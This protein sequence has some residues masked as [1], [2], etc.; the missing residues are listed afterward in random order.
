M[1]PPRKAAVF[2]VHLESATN[3]SLRSAYGALEIG[4]TTYNG[5]AG[6]PLS[7]SAVPFLPNAG[8][9]LRLKEPLLIIG[10]LCNVWW[11]A[12]VS[13]RDGLSAKKAVRSG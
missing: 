6:K 11:S 3:H 2:R 10:E 1:E 12:V 8:L 9:G 13:I 5:T 4:M 7:T